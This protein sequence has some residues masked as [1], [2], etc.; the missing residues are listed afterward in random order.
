MK[1]F[2]K[3]AIRKWSPV[4]ENIGIKNEE[5][6]NKLCIYAEKSQIK[7][8]NWHSISDEGTKTI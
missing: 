4:M 7:L 8:N 5:L 1:N 6:K 3:I 2:E